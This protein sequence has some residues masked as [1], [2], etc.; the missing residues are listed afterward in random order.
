MNQEQITGTFEQNFEVPVAQ[1]YAAWTEEE[2]LKQWW[3]P[4][5]ATLQQMTNDVRPGG[6]V[7][8]TFKADDEAAPFEISGT[9]SEAAPGAKL[10]YSWNWHLADK[11]V[12]DGDHTL[13][14]AFLQEGEGSRIQVTQASPAPKDEAI[15]PHQQ[16][17]EEGLASLKTY[18]ETKSEA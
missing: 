15:K 9:Y 4:M 17:W 3:K 1:L 11:T 18:L 13:T 12:N 6:E 7:R 16:G 8:Y 14:V 2:Q 5:G 10:V